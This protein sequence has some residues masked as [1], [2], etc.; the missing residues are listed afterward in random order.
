MHAFIS[1]FVSNVRVF[2]CIFVN[3][4]TCL[5]RTLCLYSSRTCD[6]SNTQSRAQQQSHC[7]VEPGYCPRTQHDTLC[8]NSSTPGYVHRPV[9]LAWNLPSYTV[10]SRATCTI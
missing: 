5:N 8:Y 3:Y 7:A 2:V 10:R 6:L 1:L 9:L 4:Y